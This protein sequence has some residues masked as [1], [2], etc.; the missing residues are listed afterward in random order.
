MLFTGIIIAQLFEVSQYLIN[1]GQVQLLFELH[2]EELLHRQWL[3]QFPC[4]AWPNE[5]GTADYFVWYS[6]LTKMAR[7]TTLFGT[8][9]KKDKFFKEL[10]SPGEDDDGYYAVIEA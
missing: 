2:I 3:E 6:C 1:P 10:D 9:A 4:G 7:Q 8:A 5:N